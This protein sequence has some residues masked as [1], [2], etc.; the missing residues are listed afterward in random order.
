M[1]KPAC[2]CIGCHSQQQALLRSR[3]RRHRLNICACPRVMRERRRGE[4]RGRPG[5]A[6]VPL[7]LRDLTTSL[8]RPCSLCL[9]DAGPVSSGRKA[10]GCKVGSALLQVCRSHLG[11]LPDL[12]P[13][14]AAQRR[15]SCVTPQK[16]ELTSPVP[17][18]PLCLPPFPDR[19]LAAEGGRAELANCPCHADPLPA[20]LRAHA[21]ALSPEQWRIR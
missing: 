15:R 16:C 17:A 2:S 5:V 20:H 7:T 10:Q 4:G 18:L 8:P 13:P 9:C 14:R 1:L 3:C 21:C 6:A 12:S 19:C 11:I